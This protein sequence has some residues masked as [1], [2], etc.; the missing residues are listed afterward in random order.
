MDISDDHYDYRLNKNE[1]TT[2]RRRKNRKRKEKMYCHRG[3]KMSGAEDPQSYNPALI[4][5]IKKSIHDNMA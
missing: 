3:G 5:G 2:R 1:E 4:Y